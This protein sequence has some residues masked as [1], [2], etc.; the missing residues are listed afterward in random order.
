M[1]LNLSNLWEMVKDRE[2]WHAAVRGDAELDMGEW[3]DNSNNN[4]LCHWHHITN[5][6]IVCL[7]QST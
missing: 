3:L 4:L 2:A 1:G 7:S 6:Q 5:V